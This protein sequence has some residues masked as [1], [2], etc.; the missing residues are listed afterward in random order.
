MFPTSMGM[1]RPASS[2]E[3]LGVRV[4][5]K[6]GDEPER[7][8]ELLGSLEVFPTSVGMNRPACRLSRQG[9][10]VFPTSVGMNRCAL[11]GQLTAPM[12]SP[13]AWG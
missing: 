5:H 2:L 1:N 4:P 9:L 3:G 10:N 12:C 11:A 6:R 13:Q 8:R 7:M